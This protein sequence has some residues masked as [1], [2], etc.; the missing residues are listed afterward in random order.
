M[1][2]AGA[3]GQNFPAQLEP[4]GRWS[5]SATD[6]SVDF[7]AASVSMVGRDGALPISV[8]PVVNGSDL[9]TVVWELN[10]SLPY[11]REDRRYTIT[12]SNLTRAGAPTPPV[13][14]DVVLAWAAFTQNVA[15]TISGT[16]AEGQTLTVSPGGWR[17]SPQRVQILWYRNSRPIPGANGTS[18]TVTKSDAGTAISASVAVSGPWL[19]E[20]AV[21]TPAIQIPGTPILQLL[22]EPRLKG[23]AR[24]GHVLE[25][26]NGKI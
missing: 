14:Y 22:M 7:S 25:L 1:T 20:L 9:N 12:V 15:P 3:D 19:D 13:V 5:L 16:G 24:V 10:G 18:Y 6:K 17:P 2:F 21:R 26:F 4:S 11:G 23:T 8:N